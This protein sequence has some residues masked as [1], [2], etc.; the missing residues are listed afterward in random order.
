MSETQHEGGCACGAVRYR[1]EG[2]PIFVNNCHCT[3]CQRQT[4]STSVVNAFYE[5][6]RFKLLAGELTVNVV[7]AGSGKP[8]EIHRCAK[9]GTA[10]FSHYPRLGALGLGLRVGTLDDSSAFKPDAAI[11]VANKMPW[12]SLPEG[13]PAFEQTYNPAEILPPERMARLKA[14]ADKARANQRA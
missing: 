3:L 2:A 4:G 9:C 10:I 14:L 6:E 13:V 7:P 5:T 11:F 12:V 8:H 1:V